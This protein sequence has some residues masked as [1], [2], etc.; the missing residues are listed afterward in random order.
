MLSLNCAPIVHLEAGWIKEAVQ[1]AESRGVEVA[2][3]L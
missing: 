2:A 1:F 3:L